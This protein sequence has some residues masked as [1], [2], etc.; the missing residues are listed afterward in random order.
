TYNRDAL[1]LLNKLGEQTV[2]T[3][4]LNQFGSLDGDT[5]LDVT[6][7]PQG[8]LET[9]KSQDSSLTITYA[10][11]G[12]GYTVTDDATGAALAFKA[13]GNGLIESIDYKP[14]NPDETTPA[15]QIQYI[16]QEA[17]GLT[18]F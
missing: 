17:N 1:G 11:D 5:G 10:D 7:D 16:G 3:S 9:V 8:R 4:G 6:Y 2:T 13:G 15:L 18:S 12:A 14:G